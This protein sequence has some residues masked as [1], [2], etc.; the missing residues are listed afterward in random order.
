MSELVRG[1]TVDGEAEGMMRVEGNFIV[2]F[3]MTP[4]RQIQTPSDVTS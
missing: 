4:A 1:A 2:K 3:L